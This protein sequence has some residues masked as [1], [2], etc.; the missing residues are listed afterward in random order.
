MPDEQPHPRFV[1]HGSMQMAQI[2]PSSASFSRLDGQ[3]SVVADAARFRFIAVMTTQARG[4]SG[5]E[6]VS[7]FRVKFGDCTKNRTRFNQLNLL[8]DH[9]VSL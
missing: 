6:S 5:D 7:I 9:A 8:F 3:S 1:V 2:G 4:W